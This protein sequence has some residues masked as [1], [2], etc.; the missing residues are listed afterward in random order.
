MLASLRR[1]LALQIPLLLLLLLLFL[2]F[3]FLFLLNVALNPLRRSL[4][5]LLRLLRLIALLVYAEGDVFDSDPKCY[6]RWPVPV[7]A[8]ELRVL[9]HVSHDRSCA[10]HL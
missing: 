7:H 4:L 1:Q 6:S 2:L 9:C 8:V 3:L 5:F 10:G